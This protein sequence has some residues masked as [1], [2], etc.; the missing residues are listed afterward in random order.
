MKLIPKILLSGLAALILTVPL[1]A[2][3]TYTYTGNPFQSFGGL[4]DST[5]FV[6]G[7]FTVSS[8]LADSLPEG[9]ITPNSYSFTD[10][11]QTFNSTAPPPEVTIEVGT[12]LTGAIN[13]WDISFTSASGNI[14]STDSAS[15]DFGEAGA[16]LGE[17]V[18]DPGGWVQSG[19]GTSPVP[20]P[21]NLAFIGLGVA[22][23]VASRRK[24]QQSKA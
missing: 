3:V 16:S 4:Y 15:S 12:D 13:S 6:S 19:S 1:M 21:G 9:T 20:E 2:D 7:S 8:A 22:A 24:F 11:V 18:G 5:D 23:I 14:L 17:N 10:G